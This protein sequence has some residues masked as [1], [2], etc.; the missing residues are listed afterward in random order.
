[1][2]IHADAYSDPAVEGFKKELQYLVSDH[3]CRRSEFKKAKRAEA[4]PAGPNPTAS[5]LHVHGHAHNFLQTRN[6]NIDVLNNHSEHLSRSLDKRMYLGEHG[7][8]MGEMFMILGT[9]TTRIQAAGQLA[10][11]NIIGGAT[12][13]QA[14]DLDRYIDAFPLDGS[15]DRLIQEVMCAWQ[16]GETIINSALTAE[17][18]LCLSPQDGPSS[19]AFKLRLR[20]LELLSNNSTLSPTDALEKRVFFVDNYGNGAFVIPS[21]YQIMQAVINNDIPLVALR[22][23]NYR[24]HDTILEG[25][26]PRALPITISLR[27]FANKSESQ[28]S[29]TSA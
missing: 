18:C 14:A 8:L 17:G 9:P 28:S 24:A 1:L 26:S 10:F 3:Q 22:L 16:D 6:Q 20:D 5:D 15:P 7:E 11:N 21:T 29:T 4:V 2:L 12:N 13:V 19:T 23:L 27:R 25:Q